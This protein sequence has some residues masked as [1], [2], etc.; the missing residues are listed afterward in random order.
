M[1]TQ[2]I[3]GVTKYH[4]HHKSTEADSRWNISAINSW[5]TLLYQLQ[6]IGQQEDRYLG[7]GYGNISQ[8]MQAE[9]FLISGTQTGGIAELSKDNYC[10]SLIKITRTAI[11]W[12]MWIITLMRWT[13][14]N[15]A[16]LFSSRALLAMGTIT[17][18]ANKNAA[19][20]TSIVPTSIS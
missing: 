2:E 10:A 12:T 13:A 3:E 4:L 1:F 14:L 11:N 15:L 16:S 9:K 8:R 7:Y 20:T 18:A 6:L 19:A 17:R 5:R